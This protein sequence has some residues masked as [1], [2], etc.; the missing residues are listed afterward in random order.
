MLPFA[1]PSLRPVDQWW[2]PSVLTWRDVGRGTAARVPDERAC[3][4][5]TRGRLFTCGIVLRINDDRGEAEE[6]PQETYVKVWYQCS[7]F[8]ANRRQASNWLVTIARHTA[9]DS[10]KRKSSRPARGNHAAIEEEDPFAEF[11]SPDACPLEGLILRRQAVAVRRCLWALPVEQRQSL[12][13]AFYNGLSHEEIARHLDRPLGTVKSW[14][15]RSL[16]SLR[17]SLDAEG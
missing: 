5:R 15:R 13:L 2:R 11:P 1:A 6:V 12:T 14:V 10:L 9:I 17:G 3:A 7:Q 8:N 4:C 16:M